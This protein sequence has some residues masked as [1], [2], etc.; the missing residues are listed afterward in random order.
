MPR[1]PVSAPFLLALVLRDMDRPDDYAAAVTRLR[2]RFEPLRDWVRAHPD[3]QRQG[4]PQKLIGDYTKPLPPAYAEHFGAI[5]QKAAVERGVD[6]TALAELGA[7]IVDG[8]LAAAALPGLAGPATKIL[9]STRAPGRLQQ[10]WIK[11]SLGILVSDQGDACC[12]P[13]LS[14]L[15][16]S[17]IRPETFA[18]G[19]AVP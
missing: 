14:T 4:M 12:W 7:G 5:A 18:P 11:L 19:S 15:A 13:E 10:L 8:G 16:C 9:M 6:R 17:G 1:L 3:R 2:Q